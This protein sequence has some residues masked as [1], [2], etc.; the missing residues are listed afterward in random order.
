MNTSPFEYRSPD[1]PSI[2]PILNILSNFDQS[3]CCAV[4]GQKSYSTTQ[5]AGLPGKHPMFGRW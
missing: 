1:N 3:S 2:F 5:H 4:H